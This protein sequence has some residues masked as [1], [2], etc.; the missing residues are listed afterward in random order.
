MA[1]HSQE[2]HCKDSAEIRTARY[3]SEA[4][5]QFQNSLEYLTSH[6]CFRLIPEVAAQELITAKATV[7]IAGAVKLKRSTLGR[8][9][10]H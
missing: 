3:R 7:A 8:S 10:V 6:R 2:R 1:K 4:A 5:A 9:N